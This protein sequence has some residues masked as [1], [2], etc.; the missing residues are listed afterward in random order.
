MG[1]LGKI[2]LIGFGLLVLMVLMYKSNPPSEQ[3]KSAL[4]KKTS[5]IAGTR[6]PKNKMLGSF[7]LTSQLNQNFNE[8]N[9]K[10]KWHIIFMGFTHC[11]HI[12]PT[13][14]Q[15]LKT[16]Y[17]K[18]SPSLQKKLQIVF[19]STDPLRDTPQQLKQYLSRYH[20]DFI[21]LTGTKRQIEGFSKQFGMPF[22]PSNE[23]DKNKSY[24]VSH[25]ASYY[26][27]NPKAQLEAV[28]STPHVLEN[29]YTDIFNIL[30]ASQ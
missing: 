1:N 18:L 14:M 5:L 23:T 24:E 29:I 16:V 30:K 22:M 7:Q 15:I 6:Y 9:L 27:T 2:V 25:S 4:D 8:Q 20:N 11:P 26:L 17:E 12:C 13:E 3:P 10:G 21:G 28:F 19:V